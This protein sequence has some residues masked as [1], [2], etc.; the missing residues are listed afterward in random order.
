MRR[1]TNDV[2]STEVSTDTDSLALQRQRLLMH[3]LPRLAPDSRGFLQVF[4]GRIDEP[5]T[6]Q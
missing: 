3:T 4:V 2:E 1:E 5:R 6:I